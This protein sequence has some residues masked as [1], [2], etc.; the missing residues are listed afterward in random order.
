MIHTDTHSHENDD[1]MHTLSDYCNCSHSMLL[2]IVVLQRCICVPISRT[3]RRNV[4]APFV[5]DCRRMCQFA[6]LCTAH[7]CI[8]GVKLCYLYVIICIIFK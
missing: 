4:T 2:F 8:S 3:C 7:L 1:A 6:S 5:L